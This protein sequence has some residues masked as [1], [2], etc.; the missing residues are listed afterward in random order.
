MVTAT[1][2][3]DSDEATL[4]VEGALEEPPL[5]A[6]SATANK[7]ADAGS[8]LKTLRCAGRIDCVPSRPCLSPFLIRPSFQK[9]YSRCEK[10]A[11][12]RA[13]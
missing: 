10:A 6:D 2:E 4:G 5:Q 12:C 8:R 9:V 1:D 11:E 3:G 7:K 13:V